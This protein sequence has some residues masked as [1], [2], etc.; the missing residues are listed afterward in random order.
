MNFARLHSDAGSLAARPIIS[1][2]M[3]ISILVAQQRAIDELQKE[4]IQMKKKLIQM[5]TN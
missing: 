5:K 4:I 3:F 1:E 2:I